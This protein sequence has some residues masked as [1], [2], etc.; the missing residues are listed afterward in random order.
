[1]LTSGTSAGGFEILGLPFCP[2]G[3]KEW[4]T[5]GVD[6][7]LGV[8]PPVSKLSD[9]LGAAPALKWPNFIGGW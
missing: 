5:Q 8:L 6:S 7:V 2:R 1:M 9:A 4:A 3:K